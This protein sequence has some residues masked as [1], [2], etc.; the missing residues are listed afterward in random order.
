MRSDRLDS[1]DRSIRLGDRLEVVEVQPIDGR[2]GTTAGRRIVVRARLRAANTRGAPENGLRYRQ[3]S[4]LEQLRVGRIGEGGK[5][6]R[7]RRREPAGRVGRRYQVVAVPVCENRADVPV[8]ENELHQG[9]ALLL[10]HH[11]RTGVGV[12]IRVVVLEVAIQIDPAR[13]ILVQEAVAIRVDAFPI[14]LVAADFALGGIGLLH[15]S[16]VRRVDH[17]FPGRILHSHH[18]NHAVAIQILRPIF[19]NAA[20]VVIVVRPTVALST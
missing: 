2:I 16:G 14:Q 17:V 8:R 4:R 9:S 15:Q 12:E 13:S 5:T 20:V 18:G 19:V 11:V 10:A 6:E 1:G 3:H 7:H